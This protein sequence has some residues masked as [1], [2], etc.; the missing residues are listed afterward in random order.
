[1]RKLLVLC[2]ALLCI[3]LQARAQSRTVSGTV[4][5]ENG[6][7]IAYAT[8]AEKGKI[9]NSTQT[10]AKG[11]FIL[12]VSETA[13]T[14]EVT[15]VG[16]ATQEIAIG[17]QTFFTVKMQPS[18]NQLDEVVV[19][20][21]ETRR[22]R[23]LAGATAQVKGKEIADMPVASFTKAMQGRM[24]GVQVIANNGVPGGNM[25]VRIRGVGSINASIAPLYIIDG[26]QI[27]SG[28]Q[29]GLFPTSSAL[30]AINPEDIET[31]DVI[32]DPA[33]A[34]IYGAQAANGVVII[35][36]KRGRVGKTQVNFSTY[37]GMSSVI[38][39]MDV[40]NAP[41]VAQLGYE[42][43]ANRYGANASQTVNYLA[44]IGG[45]PKKLESV[46]WQD[47]VFRN[48]TLQ[49][50]NLSFSGGNDRTRYFM[51]AGYNDIHGH[52][53]ASEFKRGSMRINIEHKLNDKFTVTNNLALSTF[54]QIGNPDAGA[55]ANPFR[56]AHLMWPS[57]KPYDSAGNLILDRTKFFGS[58]NHN[59]L[60][61]AEYS[62]W[63]ANTKKVIGSIGLNYKINSAFAF[64]ATF[65][66][67]YS[68]VDETRY[69][70]PRTPDG[71][72]VNGRVNKNSNQFLTWQTNEVLTYNQTFDRHD[73]SALA[74][75]EYKYTKQQG[76]S[77]AGT[78]IPIPLLN[79]L[80]A[81][82][83]PLSPGETF[84]DSRLASVFAKVG[85]IYSNKYILSL[86]LRRDGSSRFG[87][88][89]QFGYFPG[90]SLAWRLSEENFMEKFSDQNEL[91]LRLSYGVT[92]NDRL[93][94][95]GARTLLGLSGDYLTLP[96]VAPSSLGNA[97]TTWEENHSY[98]IGLDHSFLRGRISGAI[99]YFVSDRKRLLL[100]AP[101]PNTSGWT[102]INQNSGVLRNR[103]IEVELQ[104]HNI[105]TKN[106]RW[107]TNI[108]FSKVK[109]EVT[110]LLDGQDNI[111]TGVVV[112]R[113]LNSIF[114]YKYAGVNPADGRPMFYDSLG[115]ITYVPVARDRY[116]LPGTSDPTW[117][118]GFSNILA[119]KG[120]ELKVFVYFSGGNYIAFE[121]GPFLQRS[122]STVDRNQATSQL[123]R[124]QKPGDITDVPR[125]YFGGTQPGASS[126]YLFSDRFYEKGDYARL[127]EVTLS[128]NF[129]G[130]LMKRFNITQ[131]RF[132]VSAVN[133]VTWSTYSGFDPELLGSDFGVYPQGKQITVGL[134]L[135]F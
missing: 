86:T 58:Y 93:S 116:Y 100:N 49:D 4:T 91:K 28:D 42:A 60:A 105:Q 114:T 103:G 40:L 8:V 73:I 39:K 77:A 104:T 53:I 61:V 35:T 33:A 66:A 127:R 70:D 22:K 29:T 64:R 50:Y 12:R 102:S 36:T 63:F 94:D 11:Q 110:R 65:N 112:G 132:Y 115:E 3:L 83:V 121:D 19:V 85:Y 45:D 97:L 34:S 108:T 75:F 111:G 99:E 17:Q 54:T 25:S 131:S 30:N 125:P 7:P 96:G 2:S 74:G 92:G 79:T 20:G 122:G 88:G 37:V 76:Y 130:R 95:Y 26:V 16:Y 129:P 81:T 133:L 126:N 56:S 5:D 106:F 119:Y 48:G 59:V 107:T 9:T 128:Y 6:S 68:Y 13:R 57:N 18:L 10:D 90:V 98:N 24:A 43:Y 118:G 72:S 52:V 21:Y 135:T 41:D 123:R 89:N 38:K 47:L 69:Y 87:T 55:F 27:A 62:K 120:L 23:D 109:N 84:T 80:S 101:L 78:G 32:K 134:Q 51:S 82:A 46:D 15:F 31:I 113:Q 14:L 71:A 67:D 1:M 44:Q 117:Y 124:W